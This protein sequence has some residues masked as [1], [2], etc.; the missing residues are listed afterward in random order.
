MSL[1]TLTTFLVAIAISLTTQTA[2]AHPVTTPP[3]ANNDTAT[4]T[5]NTP[6]LIAVLAND[7]AA[8]GNPIDPKSVKVG[9]K[10]SN[11]SVTVLSNGQI[12]YTPKTGFTGPDTFTYT[13]K[14]NNGDAK[15]NVATVTVTVQPANVAPVANN[16]SA[17]TTVNTPVLINVVA[18]D[19]DANGNLDPASVAIVTPPANGTA[20][21]NGSGGVTYTPNTGFFGTDTFTYNV[22][23]TQG[24]TSNTATVTVGVNAAPTANAGP[25]ANAVTG[26]PVTLDGSG[27]SDPNGGTITFFWQFVS[28]P[29][30]EQSHG[31]RHQQPNDPRPELHARCGWG[32]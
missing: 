10:P 30:N 20:V 4:T 2:F 26:Q 3:T 25:D 18:N 29:H 5:V 27:S 9:T 15:S 16:D 11:G 31:C 6:V 23:D 21:P 24:A 1:R 12:R 7:V 13:V 19:T 8:S 17:S 22:K 32:L 14:G 28:V